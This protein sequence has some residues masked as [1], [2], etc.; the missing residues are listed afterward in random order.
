MSP[1]AR[2]QETI[3]RLLQGQNQYNLKS[4]DFKTKIRVPSIEF[5]F[6]FFFFFF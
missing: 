4:N 3:I 2:Y 5:F 6:F 1:E